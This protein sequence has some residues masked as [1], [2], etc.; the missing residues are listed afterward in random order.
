MRIALS[1]RDAYH[2]LG[3]PEG[4]LALAQAAVYLAV[5]PKSNRIYR[6]LAAA[7]EAARDTPA[8]PV[9]P[10]IRNAPTRLM[11][12]L[13]HGEGYEYDHDWPGGVAPQ[14]YLPEAVET[15][16]FY[17]PGE[18]GQEAA[19]AERMRRIEQL[20]AEARRREKS[21]PN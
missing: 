18:H 9:P 21:E 3:S 2:A 8:A 14:S 13:G 19:I 16:G 10:H 6:A 20:R 15:E 12:D 5:A 4:E 1:A 7:R 17:R 11:R